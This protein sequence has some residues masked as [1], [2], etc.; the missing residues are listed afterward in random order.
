MIRTRTLLDEFAQA[1]PELT[2]IHQRLICVVSDHPGLAM[3]EAAESLDLELTRV[4]FDAK[5]LADG[6]RGRRCFGLL[7][8]SECSDDKRRRLLTLTPLGLK[9]AKLLAPINVAIDDS[10]KLKRDENQMDLLRASA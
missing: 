2:G 10:L 8:I 7:R 5:T 3:N 6:Q 9:A 4:W 1:W